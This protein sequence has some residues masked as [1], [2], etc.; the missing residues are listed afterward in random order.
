MRVSEKLWWKSSRSGGPRSLDPLGARPSLWAALFVHEQVQASTLC[1]IRKS[2]AVTRGMWSFPLLL[3][4]ALRQVCLYVCE[5][6]RRNQRDGR[7]REEKTSLRAQTKRQ[8][9]LRV[10]NSFRNT[11]GQL[12]CVLPV[13]SERALLSS[14]QGSR[15]SN[16]LRYSCQHRQA[17]LM[18]DDSGRAP[19]PFQAWVQSTLPS[20]LRLKFLWFSWLGWSVIGPWNIWKPPSGIML[21]ESCCPCLSKAATV[22]S[23]PVMVLKYVSII[24]NIS[25]SF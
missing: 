14:Y 15:D 12:L 20:E 23:G 19:P 16:K 4:A 10:A 21:L 11:R 7:E 18:F 22:A 8:I 1:Q 6:E 24:Y 5:R 13:R 17:Q 9:S 25:V 2:R 3:S